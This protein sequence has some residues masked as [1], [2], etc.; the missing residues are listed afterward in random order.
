MALA[1]LSSI[2]LRNLNFGLSSLLLQVLLPP[3]ILLYNV[4]DRTFA[5]QNEWSRVAGM[6]A[7]KAAR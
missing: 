1:F 5:K 2:N 4:A 7:A 6:M 3:L